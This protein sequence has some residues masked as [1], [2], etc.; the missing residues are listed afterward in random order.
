MAVSAEK[1]KV[2][3]K[4]EYLGGYTET[5]KERIRSKTYTGVNPAANDEAIYRTGD[6]IAQLLDE[7]V[8]TIKKVEECILTESV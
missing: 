1:Q 4:I 3:L 2:S 6:G 7:D 5:G 8:R